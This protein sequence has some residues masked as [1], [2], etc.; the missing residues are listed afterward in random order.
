MY[1]RLKQTFCNN[2]NF[3]Q[4]SDDLIHS[5][6]RL[7]LCIRTGPAWG[8]QLNFFLFLSLIKCDYYLSNTSEHRK[9]SNSLNESA[10][11]AAP[12]GGKSG[13]SDRATV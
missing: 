6:K 11:Q 4:N 2:S 10:I 8:P 3:L 13:D 12:D 5:V 7:E 9:P 1:C